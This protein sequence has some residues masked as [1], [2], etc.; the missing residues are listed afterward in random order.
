MKHLP[1]VHLAWV[2]RPVAGHGRLVRHVSRLDGG[3]PVPKVSRVSEIIFP[4]QVMVK[5][6]PLHPNAQSEK[7]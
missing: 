2:W 4:F 3:P 1:A 7:H 5:H 6:E